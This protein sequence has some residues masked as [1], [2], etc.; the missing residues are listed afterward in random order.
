VN[1]KYSCH[2]KPRPATHSTYKAQAGWKLWQ[3]TRKP[4]YVDIK[5]AFGTTECQYTKDHAGDP[6][7]SGCVHQFKEE[8]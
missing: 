8:A 2:G 7:C 5:S 1:S 4:F 3:N 6:Q